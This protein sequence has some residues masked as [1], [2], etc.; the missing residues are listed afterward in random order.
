[1]KSTVDNSSASLK[2]VFGGWAF[3]I[4]KPVTTGWTYIEIP[5]SEI[6][7]PTTLTKLPSK[8]LVALVETAS[9]R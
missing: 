2:M 3:Q 8:N 4:V 6:G 9:Y 7:N 5:F 1:M